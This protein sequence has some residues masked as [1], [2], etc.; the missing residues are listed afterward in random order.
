MHVVMTLLS[1]TLDLIADVSYTMKSIAVVAAAA[2]V[3]ALV[4]PT[5]KASELIY[6]SP[7][8]VKCRPFWSTAPLSGTYCP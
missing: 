4:F 3:V 5:V 6:G 8:T 2:V 1:L 7:A